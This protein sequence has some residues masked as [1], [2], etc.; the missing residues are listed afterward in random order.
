MYKNT[1]LFNIFTNSY[2]MYTIQPWMLTYGTQCTTVSNKSYYSPCNINAIHNGDRYKWNLI[3][4]NVVLA[5]SFPSMKVCDMA[6]TSIMQ[7]DMSR[8]NYYV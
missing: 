4:A 7:G 2:S 1:S 6:M 8:V 5:Y 3:V